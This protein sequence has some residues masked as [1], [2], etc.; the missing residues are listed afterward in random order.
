LQIGARRAQMRVVRSIE[1]CGFGIQAQKLNWPEVEYVDQHPWDNMPLRDKLVIAHPPCAAFS[2]QNQS[3]D[4][5][6]TTAASF[7]CHRDVMN[8]AMGNRCY[9]LA[10]ESVPGALKFAHQEYADFARRWGYKHVFLML[11][12]VSFGVPQ[13]RPRFWALFFDE[14]LVGDRFNAWFTPKY[15]P[16]ESVLLMDER[17]LVPHAATRKAVDK[18]RG[19]VP[20]YDEFIASETIGGF[21]DQYQ[22][23]SGTDMSDWPKVKEVVGPGWNATGLP[24]KLNPM[25]FAPVVFHN[26]FWYAYNRPLT[27]LEYVRI[28]GFPDDYKWPEKMDKDFRMYL[29]KGVVPHVAEWILTQMWA[30]VNAHGRADFTQS[31]DWGSVLDVNPKK[32]DVLKSLSTGKIVYSPVENYTMGVSREVE[33]NQSVGGGSDRVGVD[34]AVSG[35]LHDGSTVGRAVEAYRPDPPRN[36][37][38]E[39]K[40][41]WIMHGEFAHQ[42]HVPCVVC[43]TLELVEGPS[44]VP[45][46]RL[47]EPAKTGRPRKQPS[48]EERAARNDATYSLAD[49]VQLSDYGRERS[50]PWA[51][52]KALKECGALKQRELIDA[53]AKNDWMETTMEPTKAIKWML[54]R[55]VQTEKVVRRAED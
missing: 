26:S 34:L 31:A 47:N 55:L 10:I 3:A 38:P 40:S 48:R 1:D 44:E 19:H 51:I 23:F 36:S 8:Y 33:L 20:R 7:Q 4:K 2:N 18:L 32:D 6:G 21:L 35:D 52:V 11:N 17:A 12:A 37:L 45:V 9:A 46:R 43:G 15:V 42:K 16:L 24:R 27:Q 39:L 13:W 22:K 29:S 50:H 5:R 49:G 41:K 30:N 53:I 25:G 28:M 14:A 54:N